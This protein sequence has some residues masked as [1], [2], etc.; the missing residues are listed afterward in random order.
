MKPLRSELLFLQ[1]LINMRELSMEGIAMF[2]RHSG[3][4]VRRI[5][6]IPEA[7]DLSDMLPNNARTETEN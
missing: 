2:L 1:Y 4:R 3:Y 7:N 6:P 5:T